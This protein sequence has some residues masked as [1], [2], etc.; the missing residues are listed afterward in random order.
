MKKFALFL[1]LCAAVFGLLYGAKSCQDIFA[2]TDGG[3]ASVTV[4]NL[5]QPDSQVMADVQRTAEAFPEFMEEKFQVRLQRSTKI[6]VGADTPQYQ[7]LLT[8]RLGMEEDNAPAKAQYTNGQSSGRKAMVAIDGNRK[9]LGDSSECISTTAHELFHQLQYELSDDHSGYEN[10]LFW[11][12]EGTADYAGA[13]LCEKL[14]GRSVDKWYRDARFTLQNSRTVA[15]VGQLQHTTEAERLDMMTTKA[16]HY[17]LADVMTMYL[18]QQYGGSQ[19]EQKIVAY[20]KA[21]EKDEAEKAF[22]QTFGVELSAFLQEFSQWWQQELMAPAKLEPIIRPGADEAAA[23]QFLQQVNLSRQ[24]LTRTWGQDLHG[25]YQLVLVTSPEDFAAAMAEYCHV[26]REEAQ[27]TADG[28][29][30]AENN[31][32]LFVNLARVEE[33][34]QAVF[35]SGT[36]LSR[37]FMMQQLGNDS[38][39]MAWLLRGGSYVAGV[40]RLVEDGQGTLKAYQRAWRKDLRQNAPLPTLDKLLTVEDL[41]RAM[42][43]QDSDQVSRL[44]EYAAAELVN[45]Y[46]W[47]SLYAWQA[48]TRQSG[49]GRQAFSKVFGITLSDFAA[50][51]HMMIY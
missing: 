48:A 36:M 14:G 51:I 1:V 47:E 19:P 8:K 4:N 11:L 15:S 46:G 21:L 30:W 13:L 7:E 22:A 45:R 5:G 35:V 3:L 41:Q 25:Q 50:Q 6:W 24:W 40:G 28:S 29:V 10:S 26:S 32:T 33:K 20:Y 44:C 18:L 34:R 16:K 9:K 17:T 27:K 37:L 39:G 2:Q 12:E 43:Q 31:S 49:D 42:N 38:S 23:R